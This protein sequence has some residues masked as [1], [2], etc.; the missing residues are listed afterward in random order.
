MRIICCSPFLWLG[1]ATV[2]EYDR[3]NGRLVRQFL[4]FTYGIVSRR[5]CHRVCAVVPPASKAMALR[6]S[7]FSAVNFGSSPY[8]SRTLVVVMF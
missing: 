5:E 8:W 1:P 2:A 6:S 4:H 3:K 7:K